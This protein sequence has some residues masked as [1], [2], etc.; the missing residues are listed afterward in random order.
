MSEMDDEQE[1][2]PSGHVTAALSEAMKEPETVCDVEVELVGHDGNAFAI[3][4]RVRCE[5][6]SQGVPQETID[7]FTR[8]ATSGD[9]AHLLATCM[10]YV[11]VS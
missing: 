8:E 6:K 11:R 5:M 3:I 1:Q 2:T 7:A 10:R 4:G 9:Y